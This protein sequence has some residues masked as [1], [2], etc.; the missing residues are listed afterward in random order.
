M[1]KNLFFIFSVLIILA[2]SSGVLASVWFGDQVFLGPKGLDVSQ[3]DDTDNGI[4]PEIAGAVLS[5]NSNWDTCIAGNT[6]VR[7]YYIDSTT[8]CSWKYNPFRSRKWQRECTPSVESQEI[9][10][11]N[12]C[13]TSPVILAGETM[14]AG[15]CAPSPSPS[16]PSVRCQ[17]TDNGDKPDVAGFVAITSGNIVDRSFDTIQG[18]QLLEAT[19]DGNELKIVA[20]TCAGSLRRAQPVSGHSPFTAGI[21]ETQLLSCTSVG[22]PVGSVQSTDARGNPRN[23]VA[24][25]IDVAGLSVQNSL[26][27]K[28]YTCNAEGVYK[29]EFD[30]NRDNRVNQDDVSLSTNA[31]VVQSIINYIRQNPLNGQQVLSETVNCPG[32]CVAGE[33][34]NLAPEASCTDTDG[35]SISVKGTATAGSYSGIDVCIGPDTLLEYSCYGRGQ[36]LSRQGVNANPINCEVLRKTCQNG[37]CI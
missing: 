20:H 24:S 9:S 32:G 35:N 29:A 1:K 23:S 13:S 7:E 33:C 19:C 30:L 15:Y 28:S 16:Q 31:I 10:C 3:W 26:R 11:D 14:A 22:Q 25:C 5:D 6:R 12:T 27:Y 17:D 8:D 18:S 2:L 21:C 37:A 34:R 36:Q 4:H